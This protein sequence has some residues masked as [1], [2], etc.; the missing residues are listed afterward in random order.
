M[1]DNSGENVLG[2][3]R[4]ANEVPKVA[5]LII[6]GEGVTAEREIEPHLGHLVGEII[7]DRYAGQMLDMSAKCVPRTAFWE[8]HEMTGTVMHRQVQQS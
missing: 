8:A 7:C 3:I 1:L 2:T 6:D 5:V 4:I